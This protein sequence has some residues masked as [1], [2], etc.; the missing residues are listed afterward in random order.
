M[1]S[2]GSQNSVLLELLSEGFAIH[3]YYH[4]PVFNRGTAG[5]DFRS[6]VRF[7]L[8][9][10]FGILAAV[11]EEGVE[12]SRIALTCIN[13]GYKGSAVA[14]ACSFDTLEQHIVDGVFLGLLHGVVYPMRAG[15]A[16]RRAPRPYM[17]FQNW[18]MQ[19]M[20]PPRW[21]FWSTSRKQASMRLRP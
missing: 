10:K 19:P 11:L 5:F 6:F 1:R 8:F 18:C 16:S 20:R 13:F 4:T 21:S 3:G 17:W 14:R 15:S 7:F 12:I 9:Y 2:A